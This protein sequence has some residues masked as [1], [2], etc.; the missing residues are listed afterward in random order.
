MTITKF[1]WKALHIK[2]IKVQKNYQKKDTRLKNF[3][4]LHRVI[5]HVLSIIRYHREPTASIAR[6]RG[7]SEEKHENW[8]SKSRREAWRFY[9]AHTHIP[10]HFSCCASDFC[11][12]I[13]ENF[14]K[15]CKSRLLYY[16]Q[17]QFLGCSSHA[18][19]RCL[20]L[21]VIVVVWVAAPIYF[22]SFCHCCI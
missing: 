5:Y 19:M 22:I 21:V 13:D 1:K 16:T 18:C 9:W 15:S 10:N 4:S 2:R 11:C 8:R 12:I 3:N 14:P 17:Y 6:G 20:I 7:G